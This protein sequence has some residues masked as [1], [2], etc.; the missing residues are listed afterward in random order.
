MTGL[1]VRRPAAHRRAVVGNYTGTVI[2]RTYDA[3]AV[4]LTWAQF[5][6]RQEFGQG[7]S[8]DNDA[9]LDPTTLRIIAGTPLFSSGGK[10]ALTLTGVPASLALAWPTSDGF[11]NLIIDLPSSAGTYNFT[12]L[13]ATQ[14]LTDLMWAMARRPWYTPSV[15]Q[16]AA[17]TSAQSLLDQ[18]NAA[19]LDAQKGGYAA[20]ALDQGVHATVLLLTESG[21][22]NH[23]VTSTAQWGITIDDIA[24]GSAQ[25]D[26]VQS[27]YGTQGWVRIVFD[28]SQAPSYYNTEVNDAHSRG[29]KVLGQ[30]LDSTDMASTALDAFKTRVQNY[31]SGLPTVDS[32]EVGNEING[33]WL[34]TNTVQKILYAAQYV[35]ANT[36]ARTMLTLF[37]QLGEGTATNSMFNWVSANLSTVTPYLDDV[38]VSLYPGWDPMGVS[39]DRVMWTLH[40]ALPSQKLLIGELG[41]GVVGSDTEG[42]WWWGTSGDTSPTGAAAVSVA[43]FY[44]SACMGFPFSGGGTYY[45]Y[46]D[47]LVA[48]A[49]PTTSPIYNALKSVKTL[50]V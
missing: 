3:T 13:A 2:L 24:N 23:A 30:F 14:V 27:L 45:W 25:L 16:K 50:S 49:S 40:A 18:A 35:K 12:L 31:V 26:T 15:A 41:F 11:S 8:G 38:S 29:L 5:R 1:A 33:D 43:K 4:E 19:A 20:Q 46:Y 6:A 17:A 7:N 28:K 34:G 42:V 48:T 37:W 47:E 21:Q 44:Q 39:F 22:Q 32:W 9:L 10:P 36:T